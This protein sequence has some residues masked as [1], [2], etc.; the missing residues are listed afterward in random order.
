MTLYEV[1]TAWP[2]SDEELKA[3]YANC[4]R[5]PIWE[6]EFLERLQ[7]TRVV[8]LDEVTQRGD[9]WR[10]FYLFDGS[11]IAITTNLEVPNFWK[12]NPPAAPKQRVQLKRGR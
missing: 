4:P 2:G 8:F 1:K 7:G 6:Q 12:M 10:V 5:I 9:R 3:K 11:V